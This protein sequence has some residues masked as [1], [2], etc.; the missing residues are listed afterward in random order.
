V[1]QLKGLTKSFGALRVIDDLDMSLR[2]GEA[3]GVVGPNGAGKT[4]IFNLVTGTLRQDH[5]SI[6][7]EDRDIGRWSPYR[8]ARA[9]IGR[10]Y[11]IPQPFDGLTVLENV[12][13][14][15]G[16]GETSKGIHHDECVAL[17]DRTGLLPI[18]NRLAGA[19]TVLQRKR[20]ELARALATKPR[21]LLLDEIAGGLT[22]PE[23]EE[24]VEA[25]KEIRSTGTT[26]VWIEHVMGA[27]VAVVDRIMAIHH[28]RNLVEGNPH[29]VMNSAE[30]REIYLG[31]EQVE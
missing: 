18:A 21:I 12:M 17:L 15:S 20:L 9:G 25:V 19:L 28:G 22:E 3:L 31:I 16:F 1:L 23:V 13:V 5:G 10:T 27:L 30:V 11:Q 26:I 14:G 24:L 7:F 29:D 4:T 8:R 2:E 6:E